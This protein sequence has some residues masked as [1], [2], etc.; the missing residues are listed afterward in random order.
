MSRLNESEDGVPAFAGIQPKRQTEGPA[1][2]R[3]LP[4]VKEFV[5]AGG[6]WVAFSCRFTA[7]CELVK[8]KEGEVQRALQTVLDG[9]ALRAFYSIPAEDRAAYP[10]MDKDGLDAL[11]LDRML[12][13]AQELDI[14]L[15]ASDDDD[16]T[17]LRVARCLQAHLNIKRRSKL[18]ACAEPT[19]A[20]DGVESSQAFASLNNGRWRTL[21]CSNCGT[22]SV[23][24]RVGETDEEYRR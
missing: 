8:L 1:L 7:T 16:L 12:G 4:F 23:R 11:V 24:Q 13:L 5:A 10:R 15:P 20:S 18:V 21:P 14:V 6:D 3:R 9:A 19:A 17:S 2:K 22:V